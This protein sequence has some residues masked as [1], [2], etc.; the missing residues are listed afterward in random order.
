MLSAQLNPKHIFVNSQ[1]DVLSQVEIKSF[2]QYPQITVIPS[3]GSDSLTVHYTSA[4]NYLLSFLPTSGF[5]GDTKLVI[6]Y[7][8]PGPFPGIPFPNYT[9]VHY[10]VKSSVIESTNDYYVVGQD[11]SLLDVLSNDVYSHGPLT[12]E[13]IGY[14]EG[15]TAGIVGD[16]ISFEFEALSDEAFVRYFVKDTIGNVESGILS[17]MRNDAASVTTKQIATD[18]KSSIRLSLSSP[19]FEIETS[20]AHGSMASGEVSHIWY[21]TPF[22]DYI[23]TD[24]VSLSTADGGLV[25]YA[26]NVLNKA[27]DNA[28]VQDDEY[29][30]ETDG[31]IAFNVFENDFRDDKNIVDYSTELIYNGN[32]QFTYSPASGFTGDKVF[33]YKVF[34]GLAIQTAQIVVHVD[35]FAPTSDVSYEFDILKDHD[36]KIV[37]NNPLGSYDYSIA[38][39]PSYGSVII[40]DSNGSEVL[41]CATITGDN[42]IIFIPNPGF[43]GM[44]EFD[45]EYCTDQGSCE[46]V[47]VDVNVLDSNFEDCLC[48]N[49]CVY[50]GDTNDDGVVDMKDILDT[51][52]N[53]GQSGNDRSNDFGLFWTGQESDDWGYQ[54]M[55]AGIDLKCGDA[56]GD[57]F[58]DYNDFSE[59]YN[60]YGQVSKLVVDE[61]AITSAVPIYF[62]PPTNPV[63]SGEWISLDIAIG[64]NG[65]PAL[66]FYGTAFTLNINPDIIDSSSVIFTLYDDNWLG[67]ESPLESMYSVPQDGQVDIGISRVNNVSADGVGIIGKLEFIVE[68]EIVGFKRSS[69]LNT[70]SVVTMNNILSTNEY[71]EYH[72]H[73]VFSDDIKLSQDGRYDQ[74]DLDVSMTLSPNP[75]LGLLLIESDKYS[76]DNIEIIDALGRVILTEQRSSERIYNIDISSFNQGTYFVRIASNGKTTVKKIQKID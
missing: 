43:S 11:T 67:Y 29:F 65:V 31:T 18:N 9:T 74:E 7:Y 61:Y 71:G 27:V 10:R 22:S 4:N 24:T 34:T 51:A 50:S 28:L 36:L 47:K 42:T 2:S 75:T 35:D 23:G 1:S 69:L 20:P 48:L 30:V 39:S 5:T 25:T 17:I 16:S 40:L 8:E 60:N 33:F 63:D 15:G 76:I 32:G 68:D 45:L 12:L 53:L 13:R 14:V 49:Q 54:Q 62:I 70:S 6:E 38:V 73:P 56:D 3:S 41:E 26:I 44:D 59:V 55:N 64:T 52:L 58:I 57:G 37:H 72:S 46:I 66:D 19:D 21:Y